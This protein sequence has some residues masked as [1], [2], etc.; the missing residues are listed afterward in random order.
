MTSE[1]RIAAVIVTYNNAAMLQD[2]LA[3][4][5][6]QS[7]PCRSIT[8]VDNSTDSA[9]AKMIAA[10]HP[11]VAYLKTEANL[12]TAGGFHI[13]IRQAVPDCDFVLTLDDDVRM[14]ADAVEALYGGFADLARRH[15]RLGAVRAVGS[16]HT[17]T[18]PFRFDCFAWRGTLIGR[19]AIVRS[20]LPCPDYFLYADDAEYSM[21]LAR[22]GYE[23]FYVP[24]SRIMEVRVA[25]KEERRFLGRRIVYY[26]E[27]FR[28]YYAMR[29]SLHVWMTYGCPREILK[30]LWYGLKISA[31]L[32]LSGGRRNRG[33]L[34]AIC[35]GVLDGA[36]SNLGKNPSYSPDLQQSETASPNRLRGDPHAV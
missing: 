18:L 29:N 9:S 16:R 2:L 22:Q 23:F 15:P 33:K 27:D 31:F 14:P 17:G 21:R 5:A 30:T 36:R 25:G 13:G 6:R 4:L 24:A 10:R 28:F 7:R 8:V 20:G 19:E 34:S 3:D 32:G 26:V 12:G 35:R 1:P 11:R